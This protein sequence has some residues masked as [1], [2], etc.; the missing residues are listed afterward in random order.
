MSYD[1]QLFFEQLNIVDLSKTLV[2]ENESSFLFT[3]LENLKFYLLSI[4][5]LLYLGGLGRALASLCLLHYVHKVATL[6]LEIICFAL[7]L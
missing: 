2:F 1:S 6:N 7:N 5:F 4:I 3:P